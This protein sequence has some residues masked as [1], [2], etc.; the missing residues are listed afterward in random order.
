MYKQ[1]LCL[2][3]QKLE[4][5]VSLSTF[6]GLVLFNFLFGFRSDY[7]FCK[8]VLICK[9]F[10][11]QSS[12]IIMKQA[13]KTVGI[14]LYQHMKTLSFSFFCSFR[15][16]FVKHCFIKTYSR[17]LIKLSL[18]N[19]FILRL[20]DEHHYLSLWLKLSLICIPKTLYTNK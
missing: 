19:I 16:T 2:V 10:C 12:M 4:A 18:F 11:L 20:C 3:F 17:I 6:F 14:S 7:S 9:K 13:R 15:C 5:S 1:V 8:E